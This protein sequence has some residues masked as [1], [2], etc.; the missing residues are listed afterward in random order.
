MLRN[1]TI[2]VI[3]TVLKNDLI[4]ILS[5]SMDLYAKNSHPFGQKVTLNLVIASLVLN[6]TLII[7]IKGNTIDIQKSVNII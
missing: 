6:E 3:K 1:V 2:K 5:L 4:N 7:C